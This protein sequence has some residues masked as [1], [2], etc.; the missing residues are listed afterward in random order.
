MHLLVCHAA[1]LRKFSRYKVPCRSE[2]Y[3]SIVLLVGLKTMLFL[4]EHNDI[5]VYTAYIGN[6]YLRSI[7]VERNYIIVGLEFGKELNGCT[8]LIYKA[9]YGLRISGVRWYDTL[10]DALQKI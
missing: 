10:A 1:L 9:L 6:T 2:V 5:E 8:L 4:T 3:S 7:S